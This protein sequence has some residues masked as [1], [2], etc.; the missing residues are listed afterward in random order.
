MYRPTFRDGV[1]KK[2]GKKLGNKRGLT[3]LIG[4]FKNRE[5]RGS[6]RDRNNLRHKEGR[7]KV[8]LG[9]G[10]NPERTGGVERKKN[11]RTKDLWIKKA[12]VGV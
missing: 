6:S 1:G 7:E 10:K 8:N 12:S 5:F 2:Q 9:K 11:V 4:G 3:D